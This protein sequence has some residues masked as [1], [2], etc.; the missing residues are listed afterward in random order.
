MLIDFF[1]RNSFHFFI[2]YHFPYKYGPCQRSCET[3]KNNQIWQKKFTKN[4]LLIFLILE[5][6]PKARPQSPMKRPLLT[7]L[8]RTKPSSTPLTSKIRSKFEMLYGSKLEEIGEFQKPRLKRF[9]APIYN[10]KNATATATSVLVILAL[11]SIISLMAK[12]YF[13]HKKNLKRSE[14]STEIVQS[15][16]L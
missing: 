7:L 16:S 5:H 6:L 9:L 2:F 14:S 8:S 15:S 10:A 4:V 3:L 12:T 13:D 1:K 11:V